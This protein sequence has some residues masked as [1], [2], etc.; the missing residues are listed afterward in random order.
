M[1]RIY[2]YVVQVEPQKPLYFLM[3][4][5]SEVT[6][7]WFCLVFAR[8]SRSKKINY[9]RG[10][11]VGKKKARESC[12]IMIKKVQFGFISNFFLI[13]LIHHPTDIDCNIV[14]AQPN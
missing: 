12:E 4:T 2:I 3:L 6:K 5:V 1:H 13:S 8:I 9:V 7:R 11:I 14:Y 10:K